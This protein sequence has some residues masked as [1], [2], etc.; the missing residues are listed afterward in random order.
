M[1]NQNKVN[2]QVRKELKKPDKIIG[3]EGNQAK[4]YI[5]K[6][7]DGRQVSRIEIDAGFDWKKSIKPLLPNCPDWC[8]ASHFGY[9]EEGEMIVEMENGSKQTVSAGDA[10]YVPPGHIPIIN[11]HTVMIE[12]SQDTTYSN[13]KFI[14]KN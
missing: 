2:V 7:Q 3:E 6:F 10:Y 5:S 9:L 11:K 1:E 4:M 12:F 13:K 14:N 8:P